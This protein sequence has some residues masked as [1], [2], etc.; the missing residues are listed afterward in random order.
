[1]ENKEKQF[2]VKIY[3]SRKNFKN[4]EIENIPTSQ[5]Q[6]TNSLLFFK[7]NIIKFKSVDISNDI[8][9]ISFIL[10]S[11][12]IKRCKPLLLDLKSLEINKNIKK[13]FEMPDKSFIDITYFIKEEKCDDNNL[14]ICNKISDEKLELKKYLSNKIEFKENN[15]I[16]LKKSFTPM[17]NPKFPNIS[18]INLD[19]N[20]NLE[21]QGE[22]S[23]L[24]QK[25][26]S[27][28]FHKKQAEKLN[29]SLEIINYTDLD[30]QSQN[31]VNKDNLF[32]LGIFIAGL[33]TPI[34]SS[35]FFEDSKNFISSCGHKNCSNLLSFKPDILSKY[36]NKNIELTNE[37]NYLVSNLCFPL[38]IKICY[39]GINNR[40]KHKLQ[41]CYYNVIKNAKGDIY[42]ITTLQYFIKIDYNSFKEKY[43][44]DLISFYANKERKEIIS[45]KIK[46]ESILFIPE[47]ISL[48]S[49]Y[50][51]FIP[52]NICLNAILLLKTIDEKNCLINHI[53]NEVPIPKR[54]TKILFHIPFINEPIILN[55]E[56]NI[57]K[58]ISTMKNQIKEEN[59]NKL[60]IYENAS[61]SQINTEIILDKIPIENIIFLFQLVILEQQILIVEND[62]EILS[63][64]I[65]SLISLIY[66][67]KWIN[68][69]LPILSLNTVKFL[70]TPVPYIMG[71]DE[72]L[73]KYAF[74]S[75]DIY[76]G[77]EIIVYKI[78]SKNFTLSKTKKRMNKKDIINTLKLNVMP[79][80]LNKFLI[81]ELEK[82]EIEKNKNEMGEIEMDVEIRL[83]F[84]KAM[85]ILIG[86]YNNYTF[87]T[88]DDDMTLFN[89]EAFIE[90]HKDKG[91]KLFLEQ[92]IK[93]QIFKQFLLNEK[94]LYLYNKNVNNK[95]INSKESSEIYFDINYDINNCIDTSY[96][97]ILAEK[98]PEL[99][100]NSKNRK[101][102]FDL[103]YKMDF[104][105]DRN[106]YDSELKFKDSIEEVNKKDNPLS[107]KKKNKNLMIDL[108]NLY[109]NPLELNNLS[110][111]NNLS[112]KKNNFLSLDFNLKL[113]GIKKNES[114]EY[115]NIIIKKKNKIKKYL[116]LPYFINQTNKEKSL[117]YNIIYEK[118]L[119][120]NK[121]H[122]YKL[123][124]INKL[125]NII[126]VFSI[127]KLQIDFSKID[128]IKAFHYIIEQN[129]NKL[130]D[131]SENNIIKNKEISKNTDEKEKDINDIFS[132]L[133]IINNNNN[134]NNIIFNSPK[135]QSQNFI[136][137]YNKDNKEYCDLIKDCLTHC[138]TNK[139][140]ITKSQFSSLELI[141]CD[142]YYRNYFSYLI[143]PDIKLKIQHKQLMDLAF[144]DF[145]YMIKL[146][147]LKLKEDEF[148]T[149]RRMTLAC[150]SYYKINEE[151]K[152][153][154]YQYL[155]VN[156]MEY[157][158][159]EIDLFWIEFFKI[160]M[161]EVKNNEEIM[162]ND[163]GND[164]SVIEFKSKFA[165]LMD[166]SIYISKIMIKL[167]LKND[168]IYTIFEKMIL[169]LYEYDYENINKMM[170]KIKSSFEPLST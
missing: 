23:N 99:I 44:Y 161:K 3:F 79:E 87:Y 60:K 77:K 119:N 84:L 153:Y 54:F 108:D 48:L 16:N 97:K 120:Y 55:Y 26:F 78:S 135:E 115:A 76:I 124:G 62:Y 137:S 63:E 25:I 110:K 11:D 14:N 72:Y 71:I 65:L 131:N 113:E 37:L 134:D 146:C 9:E 52:M 144:S 154:V 10:L 152:F 61:M 2:K 128:S 126:Y 13:L 82:K 139:S 24:A 90:N 132:G 88:N 4:N 111:S 49:K 107:P 74:N 133:N 35:S 168:F 8:I 92:L 85:L 170:E 166:I 89:K 116:L 1:M 127:D 121:K 150:F 103:D 81:S 140:R 91:M 141:F 47:S 31:F 32:C 50:P 75:K 101:S 39:E 112:K 149:G 86:D 57:Y 138:L 43:K 96:F 106:K 58:S 117:K 20:S 162:L 147:L 69:F 159:W 6:L 12:R 165:T 100:N 5:V 66:P 29:N 64:I 164:K 157:K 95:K 42:Y 105:L 158:I 136:Q 40:L 94:Q 36:L 70:Q 34:D 22:D 53:I 142:N 143:F 114:S 156:K 129:D 19:L 155:N 118:I 17:L 67:L 167:N 21:I 38:G 160:E 145:V 148:Q 109:S 59:N 169:R 51:F 125:K 68:P 41:K 28:I 93:T 102:S 80:V 18:P 104:K 73:L 122:G 45:K 46:D 151:K 123:F 7:N 163:F 30:Y 130:L 83:I 56:Y 27:K 33:K 15:S 98:Y